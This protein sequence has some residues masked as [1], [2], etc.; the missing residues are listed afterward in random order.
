MAP[1]PGKMNTKPALDHCPEAQGPSSELQGKLKLRAPMSGWCVGY[2]RC[3][4]YAMSWSMGHRQ[5]HVLSDCLRD[6]LSLGS[7]ERA[8]EQGSPTSQAVLSIQML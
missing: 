4:S 2:V 6:W 7:G 3:G 8:D 5:S 1:H